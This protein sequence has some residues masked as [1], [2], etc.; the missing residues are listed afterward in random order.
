MNHAYAYCKLIPIEGLTTFF[1]NH[2]LATTTLTIVS[3]YHPHGC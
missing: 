2:H 3:G 1:E